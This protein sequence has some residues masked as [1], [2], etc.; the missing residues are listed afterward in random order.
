LDKKLADFIC[1]EKS[2]NKE[3]AYEKKIISTFI[4][5]G[6]LVSIP[7][8]HKK[9]EIVL[10]VILKEFEAD[11]DYTERE[12]NM[13]IADFHDDFC[14]IR[15]HMVEFGLMSRKNSIYRVNASS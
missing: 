14:A 12:V 8:Q 9:R 15:R 4:K 10:R 6:K 11:K 1:A 5:Y 7:V 13:I 3:S 2:D